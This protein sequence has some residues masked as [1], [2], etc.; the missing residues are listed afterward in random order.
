MEILILMGISIV[1]RIVPH[2]PN[3]TAVGAL[4]LFTGSTQTFKTSFI[5]TLGAM[6]VSDMI[7]GFHP[8]MWAT[9]GSFFIT[10]LLGRW[11]KTRSNWKTIGFVTFLSSFQFFVLTNVA[12]WQTGL[13]YP[14]TLSGLLECYIMALPFFRNSLFGDFIYTAIFFGVFEIVKRLKKFYSYETVIS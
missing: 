3:M 7:L 8:V 5:V 2:I 12:V 11:L 4:A 1:S 9:Y 14:K 10:I 6:L 13:M